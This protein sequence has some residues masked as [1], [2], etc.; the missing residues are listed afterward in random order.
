MGSRVARRPSQ[1][2]HLS[3]STQL[4]SGS[5]I[6]PTHTL[7]VKSIS[8]RVTRFREG[9]ARA[10]NLEST[11]QPFA[12]VQNS[13]L[14]VNKQYGFGTIINNNHNVTN[15]FN[16]GSLK[17]N[18]GPVGATSMTAWLMNIPRQWS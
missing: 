17:R 4:P 1:F 11:V 18:V 3:F 5:L 15:L 16:S 14:N 8:R 6:C 12:T 7:A 9:F 10:I 13:N 2:E